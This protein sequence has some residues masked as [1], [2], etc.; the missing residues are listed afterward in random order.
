MHKAKE[1]II[2]YAKSTVMKTAYVAI[3]LNLIIELLARFTVT[4]IGGLIFM[5]EEPI[6]FFY[7]SLIIYSTLIPLILFKRRIFYISL[8][9]SLWIVLGGANG[10]IL[11]TR[12]TPFTV[13]DL[14]NLEDGITLVTNY[15][16]VTTII[17]LVALVLLIIGFFVV[18]FIKAPKHKS[19]IEWKKSII[20]TA[21]SIVLTFGTTSLLI[22]VG[23]VDTFFGNLAYAYRDF[24]V[25]YCFINTWLNTGI[26]KPVSYNSADDVISLIDASHLNEE[27]IVEREIKDIDENN[28]NILFLQ[29]ESFIDPLLVEGLTYS[30]DP[31]PFFR[32]LMEE[33]SSGKLIVPAC[34]AGTANTEFEVM[35]GLSVKFFGPGEY[36]YKSILRT[37]TIENLAYNLGDIGYST[38]TVHNHR[39]IFY[40]RDEVFANMGYDSFTALEYMSNVPKTPTNWAKDMILKDEI[41]NIMEKT[42]ERDYIYTISVQGHGSYPTE[43]RLTRPSIEVT[44]APTE[45]DKWKY[46]Y[47]VNQLY[48]MDLVVKEL[49]E[50]LENYDE[51]VILVLYGDHIPAI[52]L[53]EEMYADGDLYGTQYVIWSN[54]DL[55]REEKT[56]AAYELASE[57]LDQVSLEVG[58]IFNYHN[59]SELEDEAFYEGLN[60]LAYDMLYGNK[61]IY[62]ETNPYEPSD[63]SFGVDEIIIEEIVTIGGNFFIKGQNFTEFSKI[64]LDGEELNTIFLGENII[65]LREDVDEDDVGK[66]KVSQVDRSSNEIISTTE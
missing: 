7:N 29:L 27:G 40:N 54:F 1:L 59:E 47:Y 23:I 19:G 39:A 12:M 4:P 24:G 53:T 62:G 17:L 2:K 65:G 34:G 56:L 46:E 20:T 8:V 30:Q 66:M 13:K 5:I 37:D 16:D 61:Y 42:E 48:E 58:T 60:M 50:E 64:T 63:M 41:L 28:P 6:V 51:E 44:D 57:V 11:T 52:D 10:Y 14:A 49:V 18:L 31:I 35:T 3:S 21:C 36:P 55:P 33:Y 15:M 25:P 22:N 38:H 32:S 26:A 9:G 43:E 45:E